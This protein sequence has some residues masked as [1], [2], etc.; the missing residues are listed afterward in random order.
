VEVVDAINL[1]PS[2]RET[3]FALQFTGYLTVPRDG[4]YTFY[5][6]SDDGSQ[7]FIGVPLLALN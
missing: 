4:L 6:S 5:T 7:L 3:M 1:E 2:D